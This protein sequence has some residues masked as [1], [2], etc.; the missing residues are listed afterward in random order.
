MSEPLQSCAGCGAAIPPKAVA[1]CCSHC[2]GLLAFG[3]AAAADSL[4]KSASS[5]AR[6]LGGYELL[7]E[8]GRGGMGTVYRA[9]Q[10]GLGREVALKVL[11]AGPYADPVDVASFRAEAAAAAAMRHP[12]IVTVFEVGEADGHPYFSMELIDGTPLS[13]LTSATALSNR[14]VRPVIQ[15]PWPKL[16]APPTPA[17]SCIWISNLEMC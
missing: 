4:G 8:I 7:E 11:V 2:L 17:A 13:S 6:F 14:A 15:E 3:P 9:R 16:S 1:G 12:G 5:S 10:A